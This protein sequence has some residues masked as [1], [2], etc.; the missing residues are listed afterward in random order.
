[1]ELI[2]EMLRLGFSVDFSSLTGP[3]NMIS[4]LNTELTRLIL[5]FIGRVTVL[6]M[7]LVRS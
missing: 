3:L 2:C 6:L 5:D 1:M 4:S 7:G